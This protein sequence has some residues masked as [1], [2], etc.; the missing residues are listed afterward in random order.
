MQLVAV[1]AYTKNIERCGNTVRSRSAD[2]RG[3]SATEASH[4]CVHRAA[5]E[6]G[7]RSFCPCLLLCFVVVHLLSMTHGTDYSKNSDNEV[8]ETHDAVVL[9]VV[10][11][12]LCKVSILQIKIK[13]VINK[14]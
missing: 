14:R 6:I 10:L 5:S 2:I 7:P 9:L 11:Q 8:Q 4:C 1:E 12:E 3:A 13:T